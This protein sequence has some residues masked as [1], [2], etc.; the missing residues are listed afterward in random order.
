MSTTIK[1]EQTETIEVKQE[2]PQ[3]IYI[4][5]TSDGSIPLE[6]S[7]VM[8]ADETVYETVSALEQLSRGTVV[9]TEGG[10]LLQVYEE[11]VLPDGSTGELVDVAEVEVGDGRS[12]SPVKIGA[13][14]HSGPTPKSR[15]RKNNAANAVV[16]PVQANTVNA[17]MYMVQ[18][19]DDDSDAELAAVAAARGGEFHICRICNQF[20]PVGQ[21][22]QHNHEN[23]STVSD[24]TCTECGKLFKSKR[25][26]FG[27]R[28]EKHSGV[29]EVHTCPECGKTFGR[30]SNLKAHRESLHYGKKFPCVHCDRIFTNRSSMNQHIK[31]T[32]MTSETAINLLAAQGVATIHGN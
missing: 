25:S 21:L 23:H 8:V 32:H 11:V 29:M 13:L 2:A 17:T 27:H 15:K 9:Q 18:D 19:N 22:A 14:T 31:K 7:E 6:A 4:I 20:V 1:M 5:Q 16:N 30:K 24:L 26:L 12:A 3:H 28:K 10:E